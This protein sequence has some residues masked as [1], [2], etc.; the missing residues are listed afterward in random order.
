[1]RANGAVRA[2][3]VVVNLALAGM[4]PL[5]PFIVI[6]GPTAGG[7]TEL[8]IELATR[9]P[10]TGE[11]IC[12]DSMQIYRGMDIG[13]AKPSA[14]QR[15]AVPHHLLDLVDPSE[16][17]FTVDRWL[18]LAQDAISQIRGRGRWPIVVGGT[19]LYIQALLHGLFDGPEPAPELRKALAGLDNEALRQRLEAIDPPAAARIHANDRR[20]AIRAIEVFEQT[21]RRISDLQSQWSSIATVPADLRL[22]GLEYSVATINARINARVKAMF[23]VGLVEEVRRVQGSGG[24]GRQASEALGYRQVLD[25][26]SGRLSLDEATEQIKIATRQLAKQQRTW[27]KRFRRLAGSA[28][29][30]ADD[31][32]PQALVNEALAALAHPQASSAGPGPSR[33]R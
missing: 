24:L 29:V 25:H 17:G 19:N 6:V 23:E 21:G 4:S 30:E 26:L 22:I 9:L 32:S 33:D 20:R 28:W 15:S 14:A 1:M 3:A 10:G 2:A 27:L 8:A 31:L 5:N 7:T 13:T 11:C 16:D 18:A 12:A